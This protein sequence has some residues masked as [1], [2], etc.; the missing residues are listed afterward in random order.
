MGNIVYRQMPTP[1]ELPQQWRGGG[2]VMYEI[3]TCITWL[4]PSHGFCPQL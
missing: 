2:V 3:D 1:Q 4:L